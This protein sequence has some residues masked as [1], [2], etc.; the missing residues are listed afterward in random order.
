L[1]PALILG[2]HWGGIVGVAWGQIA[3]RVAMTGLH[4]YLIAHVLEVHP[5]DLWRCY[6]PALEGTAVMSLAVLL[7]HPFFH[8]WG[9]RPTLALLGLGGAA[10]YA[11]YL[12]W[13]YP[14]LS[15]NVRAQLRPRRFRPRGSGAAP[16]PVA[17]PEPFAADTAGA[18]G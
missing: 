15:R 16:L 6:A 8:S 13:R 18:L 5:R 10:I 4:L 2:A 3:T 17:L 1:P 7:L 12:H 14:Q 9:P 11:G